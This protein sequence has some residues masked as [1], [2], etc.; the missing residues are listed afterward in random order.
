MISVKYVTLEDKEFWFSLDA[1][2]AESEFAKKV[3]DKQGYVIYDDG[4]PK[5]VVVRHN[6]RR[7]LFSDLLRF[8]TPHLMLRNIRKI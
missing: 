5:E 8:H 7:R 3:R 2:M 6:Q 4:I 1:H